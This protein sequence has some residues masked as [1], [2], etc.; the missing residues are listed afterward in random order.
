MSSSSSSSTISSIPG[1]NRVDDITSSISTTVNIINP[2]PFEKNLKDIIKKII[3][4]KKNR[5]PP[6]SFISNIYKTGETLKNLTGYTV[7]GTSDL[8]GNGII[9]INNLTSKNK[10]KKKKTK[11]TTAFMKSLIDKDK[12]IIPY[13]NI[14]SDYESVHKVDELLAAL[15]AGDKIDKNHVYSDE[16]KIESD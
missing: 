1:K 14:N 12:I 4:G 13:I 5:K 11:I 9:M 10:D 2:D 6:T 16:K 7:K 8:I 15:V 3:I